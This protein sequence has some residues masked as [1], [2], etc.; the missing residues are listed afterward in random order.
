MPWHRQ[1]EL[2]KHDIPSHAE[3]VSYARTIDDLRLRALFCIL[4]LTGA[5]INEVL[6]SLKKDDI[7]I[8]DVEK[9][10][11]KR[12]IMLVT[13]RN[14]KNKQR[15]YKKIPVPVDK[16]RELITYFLDYVDSIEEDVL[17]NFTEQNA[18]KQMIK[19]IGVNPHFL[20]HIRLTHLVT[21]YDFN[22]YLLGMFAGW[23]DIRPAKH[24]MELKWKD[25]LQKY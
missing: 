18:W 1:E 25:I 7:D 13:L 10:G 23:T 5:R 21:E 15:K 24:Y 14:E 20:R 17:F 8:L 11:K 6:R 2:K 16:E 9:D 22:E 3:I 4:Y 12:Q 19:K